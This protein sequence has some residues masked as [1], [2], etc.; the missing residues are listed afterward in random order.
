MIQFSLKDELRENKARDTLSK[1]Q[2][3]N[4]TKLPGYYEA[5]RH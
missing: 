2:T 4:V 3:S 5:L 1:P